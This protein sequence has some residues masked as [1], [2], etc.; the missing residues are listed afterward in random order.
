MDAKYGAGNYKKGPTSEFS[1]IQKF[2]DRAFKDPGGG[3]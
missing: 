3:R 1:Q 2:G